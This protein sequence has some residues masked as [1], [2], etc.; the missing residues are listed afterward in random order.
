MDDRIVKFQIVTFKE[1]GEKLQLDQDSICT[2]ILKPLKPSELRSSRVFESWI[3]AGTNFDFFDGIK[4]Q[5]FFFRS[6]NLLRINDNIYV[7]FAIYK[8]RYFT[9]DSTT[10]NSYSSQKLLPPRP[11]GIYEVTTGTYRKNTKQTFDPLGWQ[12]DL[13]YKVD[14]RDKAL[15]TNS[16]K[17]IFATLGFDFNTI[18][19]TTQ[20]TYSNFDTT[21]Y[22]TKMPDTLVSSR[23]ST[24]LLPDSYSYKT[25]SSNLNVGFMYVF[26][27]DV[28]NF[29]AHFTAGIS[30]YSTASIAFR[31]RGNPG[32]STSYTDR[33]NVYLQM[34][35]FGTYKPLGI[36]IGFEAFYRDGDFLGVNAT[37][38]KVFDLENFTKILSPINALNLK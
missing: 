36:S 4:A 20:N 12:M 7:Q 9:N 27:N 14:D 24:T 21:T 34:R 3:F 8:N 22:F 2:I 19:V 15:A 25:K 17:T 23:L 31:T 32:F 16:S 33:H 29:K 1:N 13:L 30:Y 38:S 11:E 6:N 18:T 10:A 28:I 37:L 5:E 35:T 26:D